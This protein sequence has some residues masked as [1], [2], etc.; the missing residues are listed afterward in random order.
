MGR[1]WW[2]GPSIFDMMGRDPARA[3]DISEDGPRL[4]AAVPIHC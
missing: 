2:A 1:R 4:G 3:V